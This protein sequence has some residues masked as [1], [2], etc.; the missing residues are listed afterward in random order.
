M[1]D[2]DSQVRILSPFTNDAAA[3]EKAIRTTT[4]NGSTS[5]YNAIYIAL[6]EL[7]KVKTPESSEIRRQAIVLLSD[8]D[9][10]SSLV[11]FEVVLERAKRSDI[12]IYAIGLRAGELARRESRSGVIRSRSRETAAAATLNDD[13]ELKNHS[14]SGTSCQPTRSP[15]T[16]GPPSAT[17]RCAAYRPVSSVRIVGRTK[18]LYDI[19][20]LTLAS[21]S[22]FRL[23]A[24]RVG[25]WWQW[26]GRG[27]RF[28]VT[29][30]A[31]SFVL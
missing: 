1:I 26:R 14:R 12:A 15:T 2:F 6:S 31:A 20:V 11:E 13:R 4:P 16:R 7:K 29:L 23:P 10:T 19:R 28:N 21:T 17:A 22:C 8:G 25:V 30:S 5:L 18:P 24:S 9:D 27:S 3:L